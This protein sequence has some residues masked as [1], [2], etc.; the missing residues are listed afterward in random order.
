MTEE[1]ERSSNPVSLVV[2]A[3]KK[4]W[5]DLLG[6]WAFGSRIQGNARPD[7]DWDLAILIPGAYST[8][9]PPVNPVSGHR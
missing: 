2:A 4:R 7:S 9:L 1:A 6:V 5:R 8:N 3:L